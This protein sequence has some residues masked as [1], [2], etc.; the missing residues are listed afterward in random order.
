MSFSN[1]DR[2]FGVLALRLGLVGRTELAAA[3]EACESGVGRSLGT[4]LL[5]QGVLQPDDHALVAEAVRRQVERHGGAWQSLS[6]L[7]TM[8]DWTAAAPRRA[9]R[10]SNGDGA[11]GF[12]PPLDP[13]KT[14]IWGPTSDV[15]PDPP[16][17]APVAPA[18]PRFRVLR[19]HAQGGLGEVSVAWDRELGR[20]VALKEI[21]PQYADDRR[22]RARF[23]REAEING[24]LEHPGIVPVY[25][26]GV[27]PEG[28]PYYAMRFVEGETLQAALERVAKQARGVGASAWTQRV[29]PL[30]KRFLVVCE[31]IEY[32][33]SRRVVHRDLKPSNIL[34]GMYGETLI[35]DWGLAKVLDGKPGDDAADEVRGP[36][37]RSV[38][39]SAG[40]VPTIA[41]ETLG[42]P[43]YMSPEQADG[44]HDDLTAATDVYS[45]GATLAA[46]LTGRPPVTGPSPAIVTDKV[47]RGEI[48][49]PRT[50]NP[51]VPPALEAICLKALAL[52]PDDRYPSAHALADD[53]DHWLADLPV[54]V[55]SDPFMTRALR[56]SRH[57][58]SL[59]AA[60]LALTLTTVAALAVST[61]V[62]GKQKAAAVRARVETEDA[63]V[64]TR[65]AQELA[66]DHLKIGLDVID[67]LISFGD[68]QLVSPPSVEA[69]NKLLGSAVLFI[70]K[71]RE[72]ETEN[73]GVRIQSAQIARRLGNLYAL[74][75][76]FDQAEQFHNESVRTLRLIGPDV[77][78]RDDLTA[79]TLLDRGG[80]ALTL[81]RGRAAEDD[82]RAAAQRAGGR[83]LGRA[84]SLLAEAR[85][86]RGEPQ[87]P[88]SASR[89]PPR[90]PVSGGDAA[91]LG[92]KA[93]LALRAVADPELATISAEVAKSNN[94]PLFDQIELVHALGV[95]A[96]TEAR[97]GRLAEAEERLR[98]AISR[99][100]QL[101]DQFRGVSLA[102]VVYHQAWAA[103]RLARLLDERAVGGRSDEALALLDDAILRLVGLVRGS[104]DVL[105]FRAALADA[106][107]ARALVL[108][109]AGKLRP[110]S[111]DAKAAVGQLKTLV[112]EFPAV[113]ELHHLLA[114]ALDTTALISPAHETRAQGVVAE[115]AAV[116]LNH[117][118]PSYQRRLAG[119]RKRLNQGDKP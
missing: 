36:P 44:R 71:F 98:E 68:R 12:E 39:L 8:G 6:A 113:P 59:V 87:E 84:L 70:Q 111:A 91:A 49:R 118:N 4:V 13:T 65:A 72:R 50:I 74:T 92:R 48:D 102:D 119:L 35:I 81:G 18:A 106:L 43:P 42:S 79:E 26:M 57:H 61:T 90:Y 41:G 85:L 115:E 29:R 21:L 64:A 24:G 78:E 114:D 31:A 7:D 83:T 104:S 107:A 103:T 73:P 9:D 1:S 96:E 62:V 14:T 15:A 11:S 95:L 51:R 22:A 100:G 88:P 56:W 20:P 37:D 47:V 54:C 38:T 33:H 58:R 75:G 10:C 23:V 76:K 86:A 116:A 67:Q 5:D 45:L 94:V 110:A 32:A 63:L 34:L 60:S 46:V 82:F 109:H 28:R 101:S 77:A 80:V 66:R 69:R 117:E 55:Y 25:G 112:D 99:A 52:A 40:G 53:L 93:V 27:G 17:V 16:A 3:L 105:H 30:L 89:T 19:P 97:A 2:L 108:A